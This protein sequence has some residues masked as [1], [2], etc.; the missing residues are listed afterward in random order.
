MEEGKKKRFE[1]SSR[2]DKSEL[3]EWTVWKRIWDVEQVEKRY[4]KF[5][6]KRKDG[7]I[8]VWREGRTQKG[9]GLAVSK[10]RKEDAKQSSRE[11]N[12]GRSE[13]HWDGANRKGKGFLGARREEKE[14]IYKKS[15]KVNQ[16][17]L[18]VL[19]FLTTE[20]DICRPC[21]RMLNWPQYVAA[22]QNGHLWGK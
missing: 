4:R 13:R 14:A 5:G 18:L 11:V 3:R 19:L 1:I 7:K 6:G 15:K 9:G 21:N 17:F 2:K 22:H 16:L 8:M 12:R 20:V 10:I